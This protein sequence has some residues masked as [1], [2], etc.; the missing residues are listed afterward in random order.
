M[1]RLVFVLFCPQSIFID[2]LVVYVYTE[3][4]RLTYPECLNFTA[5]QYQESQLGIRCCVQVLVILNF[6]AVVV[7]I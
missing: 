4:E 7:S 5:Q 3:R 1:G 2:L 6:G